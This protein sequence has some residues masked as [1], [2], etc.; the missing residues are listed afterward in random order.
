MASNSNVYTGRSSWRKRR[1]SQRLLHTENQSQISLFPCITCSTTPVVYA[2]VLRKSPDSH[3]CSDFSPS[4]LTES[5][6]MY[7]SPFIRGFSTAMLSWLTAYRIF[8]LALLIGILSPTAVISVDPKFDPST[9][10]RLVLVPADAQVGSVIYR[11]RATDEEFDYPLTFEFVG[12]ASS[13]TVK[14]ESLPC[15][16]Y[17]SVCQANVVL[18]R[19]LEPG[20]YYDFQVS[21][22]DTKGGM[23]T[24][25]CSIT[26]T[27]FT[28]PHELIFP[29]KP[30]IIMIPEDA[31]RGT[32]LDYVI[33]RK[34]PLF[35]KPVY[36][37]LWGSPLFAIRQKIVSTETTE[38]TVFLLG[39]LDFE[40][41]AMYHLTILANDAYAEPGQDSR[42]IAG[43]EVV[44][45]V[46][47]IQ[48]QPPVFT[49]APP[50][51]KLPTGILPGDKILQVHAED[52]DKG[53]PREVRYGLVSEGNPFTSFFDINDTSGEI[54][55]MRP[56]ED[57]AAITHVGDP[58]LLT[59]I[60][61]EVK[62]GR[63]EPPAMAS[64][65]QLAFFLPE[66][67]N[68]PP[69]FE[70][71]HY[72]SR[73][74]ENAPQ[75]TAL[76][77]VDPYVPRVYD[78]DTGKNGVFSL[79][80]LNN[81]GTFEITPNVAERSASFLI[82]VRD[83]ILLDYEE[84]H[85]VQFHILAQELGPATNLS[86]IV[87][88]T[89]YINDVN[90]N[91]PVFSQAMYTVELPENM[92]VGTKVIQVHANDA[93]TGMGGQVRYTAILGYLNTSLNLDA[94][95]GLITVSTN[96]HG[97]DRELMPEYH[98]YVEAR[99]NDG[100]GNRVQVP[101]VIKLMDVNDETPVFEKDVYEFILAPDL[102]SFTTAAFIHAVDRD[103]T[104]PNNEVR[105]EI[106]NGNYDNN[107]A[108][109]E[110]TGEL[111]VQ[112][113]LNFQTGK[114][115]K[116]SHR[117]Q[118]VAPPTN[119]Q[120]M[121]ILTARAY[122]LGIPIRSSTST[123]RIY[124]PE[125]RTRAVTFV[126]P[127]L[128]PDK[129]KTEETLST[130]TGG[131]VVIHEI[132]PLRP[133]ELG[134]QGGQIPGHSDIK[135]KS[136]V[137]A[138][139]IYD[140]ASVVDISQIQQRLSQHNSS[141]A[142]MTGRDMAT[143]ETDTLYK[144][145][146]KLLFWLLILLATLVAL[147][148]LILL[149]CCIC[150]WCPLYG[151]T[152]K[153]IVNINRT[154]DDVHLVHREMAN[155]KQT[156]SVQVAEWMGKREAW[157][158]DKQA[159]TRTKPTRWEFHNGRQQFSESIDDVVHVRNVG[160]VRNHSG[161][162][163][164]IRSADENQR[165]VKIKNIRTSK[166]DNLLSLHNSRTNL[167][168]D[169][170]VFIEDIMDERDLVDEDHEN[171]R[172]S[173]IIRNK[174][175]SYENGESTQRQYHID[176][177]S[178]RRH[179][180]DRGSDI[181]YNT[182]R[183]SLRNKREFFIK[184]GNIEILQLMTRDKTR[185]AAGEEDNIY[186]NVPQKNTNFSAPQLLMVDNSGK[187]ILMRRFIEEQPDGKQIIREHYQIVPGAT[188]LQSMPNEIQ[189]NSTLKGDTFPLGKS[190][191]NSIVYSQTEP[192]VKVIHTQ[193]AQGSIATLHHVD[194][195]QHQVQ[196]ATSN[197]SLTQ[198]LENSLKHQNELL[199]Q[200]LMEKEKIET[201]YVQHEVALE[202]QSLPG[203]S[204]AIATQTECEAGT[205]TETN[206]YM[207]RNIE[208]FQNRSFKRRARSENDDSA[209]DDDDYEYIRLSSPNSPDGI[210]YCIKRKK[211]RR[212]GKYRGANQP[213]RRIVM[214]E[215]IK[216][217]IR[218]PIKEE[219]DD[220]YYKARKRSTPQ[221]PPRD[222]KASILRQLKTGHSHKRSS[223]HAKKEPLNREVLMEISDSLDEKYSSNEPP[224]SRKIRVE[225]LEYYDNSEGGVEDYEV[226]EY[227]DYISNDSDGG[228]I[229]IKGTD[230][231][232]KRINK[233]YPELSSQ[234]HKLE[235]SVEAEKRQTD[236]KHGTS[237]RPSSEIWADGRPEVKPRLSRSDSSRGSNSSQQH[238]AKKNQS[239]SKAP[240]IA[241][242]SKYE[243]NN[244]GRS[245]LSENRVTQS[246]PDF[247]EN[248]DH[249][250]NRARAGSVPKY[251]EWYYDRKK[252]SV[253]GRT[254]TDSSNKGLQ[255]T[256]RKSNPTQIPDKK[257]T[258]T[259]L[260][261]KHSEKYQQD[262]NKFKPEPA[263][264]KS[265]SK[266]A[267]MLKEDFVKN[268]QLQ[269]RVET[270]TSHPLV[271]HSE[272]RFERE[273][274]PE[275]SVPPSKLPHYIYPE[276][277]P[278]V[279]SNKESNAR[280]VK[281]KPS[282]IK[283]NEVKVTTSSKINLYIEDPS[284]THPP[285][286]TSSSSSTSAHKQLNAATLEDDLDSGIAMNSLLNS[287]GRRNPIAEKKSVFSIAYDDVSR[288]Q[289]IPS[290]GESPPY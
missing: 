139:V 260:Q 189:Q 145:E 265:P 199:R 45:I 42:N 169:R 81:N 198:E 167:I 40:K 132:R 181:D 197:Q 59:V 99:D 232:S 250:Y 92:T 279:G 150:S 238:L 168:N 2:T 8:T 136:V 261:I 93:D 102:K 224:K 223:S 178:M 230:F 267:R 202:T 67:T 233:D 103:A 251:M 116:H 214:V 11:L 288:V 282:P 276:T 140:S 77:F 255:P 10:M 20:R 200:I 183:S 271:Q 187:E 61:E 158:A 44:V 19:R 83:N 162:T 14:I 105:Y 262:D 63:D 155:G 161:E 74:D 144:A 94:E 259:R 269:L 148:I 51:T 151:A 121:F 133:D 196:P 208:E 185:E 37:E 114:E 6:L 229:V 5:S 3:H 34:N 22:K 66:R 21:V 71:D 249:S 192:E 195:F 248:D 120:N 278:T 284:V 231:S 115:D 134:T 55:L 194:G 182:A 213:R 147:T 193:P 131:K 86:A 111:T 58:V 207:N 246:E 272:H 211:Q 205:Q 275:V 36:L 18:Q 188:Y 186:M 225:Q 97:F 17:N 215:E 127:G 125:S 138:T 164:R 216:R 222:T 60:A 252:P 290:G 281:P 142:I 143:N 241:G 175:K 107:F 221:K 210:V 26:A 135:E 41:Q 15:T 106:I 117:R 31:K 159:D 237:S 27:N 130:I 191:P 124:P 270:E 206:E 123:I 43:M 173:K 47:D 73:V 101:L 245:S 239:D 122:D 28:T 104:A 253:S 49:M 264:R 126:V 72:I 16:K 226:N 95:T 219:D 176:D 12:D 90:D 277:P 247:M 172:R 174:R 146:N 30:G 24:Q 82:R 273:N 96:N 128:H 287:M 254:S 85:T 263:P 100:M 179:E 153:R 283:E 39:P 137:T 129:G 228:E 240:N 29:H 190:G 35:Q 69:Y 235:V 84:R 79:T 163:R 91:S 220:E 258:K 113:N 87:N 57:I 209:S 23:A 9:R 266:G 236:S 203:Q 109:D 157:S 204:M 48:D 1:R 289:K 274:A 46:Q 62:V 268:K 244:N 149:L 65:V 242:S 112:E 227:G 170:D 7:I 75:G 152:S 166:D 119:A 98:L 56:L 243:A 165:R 38:G 53:S 50:V 64:T 108:L 25:L 76:I 156:K 78:D 180:I 234:Q 141:F 256:R 218:T 110:V 171:F 32:E 217:K 68:S 257:L 33:A 212:R 52:G 4:T 280:S 13:S 118:A 160:N 286:I 70:N 80:L 285:T 154:E 201:R 177:D 88:V 54:F 89:V 184:D